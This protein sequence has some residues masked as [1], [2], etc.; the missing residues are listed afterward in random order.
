MLTGQFKDPKKF[1]SD[2][3]GTIPRFNA[4]NF[5]GNL[6][7]VEEFEMLA[8]K[9]G[10]T[11]GQLAIAWVAAQGAIPIPGTKSVSR[12]EENWG[13]TS[14]ELTAE[15][16]KEIREVIISAEPKGARCVILMLSRRAVTNYSADTAKFISKWLVGRCLFNEK[17]R[18]ETSLFLSPLACISCK[19]AQLHSQ[20]YIV[21]QSIKLLPL[22]F[23]DCAE[24]G[25]DVH[26]PTAFAHL[27]GHR[28]QPPYRPVYR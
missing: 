8:K 4:E 11:P 15:E 13:A 19:T 27:L 26:L 16:L 6:K 23:G 24:L 25:T 20:S 17:K 7:L 21:K 18:S 12:L 28:T 22:T 3:R 10:C 2:I 14:V 1:E 9:K 5:E